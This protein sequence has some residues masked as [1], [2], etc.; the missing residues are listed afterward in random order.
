MLLFIHD[1]LITTFL[2]ITPCL[3]QSPLTQP[4]TAL[5]GT[6]FTDPTSLL[7]NVYNYWNIT[8]DGLY[9][10]TRSNIAPTTTPVEIP[11]TGRR[12]RALIEPSRSALVIIDM[13]NY[14]LHP[15]LSPRATGGRDIVNA[16]ANMIQGFRTN[17]MKVLWTFWGLD[18][19]DLLTIPPAFKAGFSG[20]SNLANDT[21][22]SDMG[23]Y[24]VSAADESQ[25]CVDGEECR[26]QEAGRL[27]YRG[28]W[29][30]QPWGVLNDLKVE[31]LAAGTD[32]Y[33]NKNRLSGLWGAQTPLGLWL[34]ENGITTLF[35]GGV[36][37][38]QCKFPS[39]PG[40]TV[41]AVG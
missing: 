25:P 6:G 16:T 2:L 13:Q 3:T 17:G 33:F 36:N 10:L 18:D 5:S 27:L 41:Q 38:D 28:S 37:A 24:N 35:F 40:A 1:F 39:L 20:G 14:F 22:G 12:K 19:F 31:G 23:S 26:Q 30:A 11:M 34:Q 9:D 7:G 29:N 32:Y 8:T 4:Q 15:T 21:F